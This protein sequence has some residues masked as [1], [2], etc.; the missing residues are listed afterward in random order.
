MT[1]TI[2]VPR[3]ELAQWLGAM[4]ML[5]ANMCEVLHHTRKQRHEIGEPCAATEKYNAAINAIHSRLEQPEAEPVAWGMQ[6]QDGLILDIITPEE[7]ESHEGEYTVPLYTTPQPAEQQE[8]GAWQLQ[9]LTDV[10]TAS[11]LLEHG[12]QSKALAERI[13]EGAMRMRKTLYTAPQPAVREWVGLT[14]DDVTTS[15]PYSVTRDKGCFHAGA[16]WADAALRRKN[17]G[18]A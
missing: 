14:D 2:Q 16:K 1:D 6:R 3:A 4:E 17:G 5:G 10:L 15:H 12:K 9:F 13:G 18:A 11:G 7:H 8:P